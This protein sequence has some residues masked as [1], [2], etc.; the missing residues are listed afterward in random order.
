[1]SEANAERFFGLGSVLDDPLSLWIVAG[2]VVVLAGARLAVAI[3]AWRGR[4]RPTR[5]SWYW[6]ASS[7]WACWGCS[8]IGS[9]RGPR[10]CFAM[11]RL[12]S[13]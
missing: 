10:G 4:L 11:F 12:A 8:A 13:G 2:L 7:A 1:M 6:S 5:S 3:L 9:L